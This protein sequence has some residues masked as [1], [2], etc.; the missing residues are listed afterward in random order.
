MNNFKE[1]AFLLDGK[2]IA[3]AQ[4]K[5]CNRSRELACEHAY[6]NLPRS[7]Y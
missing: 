3:F 6:F 4:H 1:S 2:L 5:S 7:Q